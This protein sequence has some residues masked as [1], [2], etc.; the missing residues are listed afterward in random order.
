[1]KGARG[2]VPTQDGQEVPILH[3]TVRREGI[4]RKIGVDVTHRDIFGIGDIEIDSNTIVPI[5][6]VRG[7]DMGEEIPLLF[8][9][10]DVSV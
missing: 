7:G 4:N 3:T 6:T 5:L 10:M 1:M 9:H 2:T 8:G